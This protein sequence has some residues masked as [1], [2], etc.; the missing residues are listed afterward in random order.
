MKQHIESDLLVDFL[1]EDVRGFRDNCDRRGEFG[2]RGA[3]RRAR[4]EIRRKVIIK[5]RGN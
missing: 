1:G 4:E 5:K 2:Q 3:L